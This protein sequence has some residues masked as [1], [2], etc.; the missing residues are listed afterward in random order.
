LSNES[1][2]PKP[3]R[4]RDEADA[5]RPPPRPPI[6]NDPLRGGEDNPAEVGGSSGIGAPVELY[7]PLGITFSR[8]PC[9]RIDGGLKSCPPLVS[10]R[11]T[12]TTHD[13]WQGTYVIVEE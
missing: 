11:N 4:A 10:V 6:A 3:P 12:Y 8:E 2:G 13:Q 9:V 7:P 5:E 1:A